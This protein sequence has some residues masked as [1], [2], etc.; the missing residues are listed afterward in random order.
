MHSHRPYIPSFFA[1]AAVLLSP[2]AL[3]AQSVLLSAD[4]FTLFGGSAI[5]GTA[6]AGTVMSNGNVGL[7]P[8]AESAI[9]DFPPAVIVNGAIIGT[10]PV[11]KHCTARQ[12]GTRPVSLN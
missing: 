8:T 9:T 1:V 12:A 4:D 2:A 7:S 10:V 11:T 3:S 6:A 5:T